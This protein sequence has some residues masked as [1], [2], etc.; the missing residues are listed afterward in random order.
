MG[1]YPS[2]LAS[3][4]STGPDVILLGAV[5]LAV[6]LLTGSV[7]SVLLVLQVLSAA[8]AVGLAARPARPRGGR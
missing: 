7:G 8:L 6:A 4:A 2:G 5:P 1:A 3:I